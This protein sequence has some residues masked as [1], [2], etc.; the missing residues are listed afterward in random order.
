[1]AGSAEHMEK[2]RAARKSK[3]IGAPSAPTTG[4][5]MSYVDVMRDQRAPVREGETPLMYARRKAGWRPLKE[6]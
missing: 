6:N 1:M 3:A 2:M 5:R 4:R